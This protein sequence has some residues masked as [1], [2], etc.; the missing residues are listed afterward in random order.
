[1]SFTRSRWMLGQKEKENPTFTISLKFWKYQHFPRLLNKDFQEN[2][3]FYVSSWT[4]WLCRK[5]LKRFR[6][7]GQEG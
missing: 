1:M 2:F 6:K 4:S 7:R 5:V 3:S